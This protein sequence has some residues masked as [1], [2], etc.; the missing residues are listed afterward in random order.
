MAQYVGEYFSKEYVMKNV[1]KYSEQDI[2]DIEG[3]INSEP[4]PEPRDDD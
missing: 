4:E 3:Q 1:L 2:Q